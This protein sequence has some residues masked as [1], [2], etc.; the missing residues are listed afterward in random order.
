MKTIY[1]LFTAFLM[2]FNMYS[3]PFAGLVLEELDN[4]GAVTGTTY[5]LYAQMNE[6]LVYSMWANEEYSHLIE[7]TTTF[8]QDGFGSDLQSGISTAFFALAPSLEWDSWVTLGDTYTDA[9]STVGELNFTSFSTSSWSFGGTVN[10]DASIF[11]TPDN[12]NCLP[13]A[14]GLVLLGQFTTD[15]T[16]SGFINLRGKDGNGDVWEETGIPIPQIIPGCTDDSYLEYDP[17]AN[18]DDG[19]CAT[20][21]VEGCIDNTACNYNSLANS[22]DSSCVFTT[23]CETCSGETDGTGTIVDNDADDDGVC[24]AD[25]IVGCFDDEACNFN[26]NATDIDNDSCVFATGCDTCSGETDGTGTIVDNDADDDGVCDADEIAGCQDAT[27]CNY[28][29]NATDD[30]DSCIFVDGICETCSGETDGTGTIV[31]NDADDDG[32]CDADEIAGCQD[33][34]ACNYNENATDDDDSCIF[35]DGICETCSGETDGTGTI[36]DNDADDDG[37]CDADEIVGC[38]DDEACNFNVN[39]TDIDND[40]CVFATGCESCSGDTDGTGTIVDNDAD[41]DGVCDADEI[42][43]CQDATACN[44][45]E[46][47]TDEGDCTYVDGICETC[48]NGLIVDNDTDDDGVCDVDEIAGCQEVTACNYNESATDSDN[49]SCVFALGCDTCTGETDGT[50]TVVDN[51]FDDDGVCDADEIAGCQDTTACNY[52]VLA[53]DDDDSCIFPIL[54]CE[55]CSGNPLDGSGTV[56]LSDDDG[57]GICNNNEI[58]GCQDD[59]ACNYN[60]NA[61]DDDDSCI[62]V[63]GICETCSGETD[64]TGTIVDNDADDDGVCDADEI[65]GCFDDEAC[66]FNVNATD[67]DNDSCV[68]AT[69][70]DTCSGETDGTGTIV[71][72]DAD[73]DGVCDADE[74]AGCQDATACNYNENATDDDDSCIF[75]DGICETCSGETDGTGTIVDNDADD[76][77][78]CDADEIAGCQDAT[79]CN[80]NENATDD[81]DS[82]I[83]VDGI[84]ETCSGE[85]DGTGTI[86]DNDADDDGV[87]D[88]DEIVGCFDDEAC[89]FNVNATDIDNDSCVFAT[90][91]ESCSGDTDGTGTIVDNDADD[92]GVCD[93]DEIAGCQDATACN[94]NE[95]ATD[96]DGSCEFAEE[97]YDCDGNCINDADGDEICDELEVAGCQDA[98]AC[99]YNENATDDDGSCEYAEEYYDCDGNC[100]NDADGDEICDELEVAG[101]TDATACNYNEN[102]T[103]DDGSCEYAEE[104]YDCDGNCIND[105]DG[106]EIC[107]EL[108]VAG[109]TDA[110]ACNYNENATDDDGSCEFAEEYYDCDGNCI[111][112]ADGDEICDELEVAGCTDAT[113]CNYNENAT[114]D[115]GSCEYAEEYYDC[116]GNC[117]NDADGD[118]ICDELEVAGCTDATACNYNEN[119][120]DDDGSCEYAEE[121]YDCD[122]NCI[123]DADGDEICDELEVAGCTDAT[124]CNYNENATDDDGSCE[125]AE[126]YYDCDGNCINDADGDEICDELEVAGCTDATA[127]NYNENATDD[128][129]SCEYAEEYYDCDGNCINDAD[130]DEICDELDNCVD[131]FNPD[132]EDFDG[133]GEGDECDPDDGIGIDEEIS[134]SILVFPNPTNGLVNIQYLNSGNNITL[135]II[136]TIGQIIETTE[137]NSFDSYIN[138]STDLGNYGKG[139]YQIQLHDADKILIERVIVD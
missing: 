51:D 104:Y 14:N 15:G 96:D 92:D 25:E 53:T 95:N 81:D 34:T 41:D 22:D 105:A 88:A 85:T 111:N 17:A 108:E 58:A 97:Y 40:S 16:L 100:I 24:D 56:V 75:V 27:A 139:I 103:D 117:I 129:G 116:D 18:V 138:Y 113:A 68:F 2:V 79:A 82:C 102:A 12:V 133:D 30:D 136:N 122:G 13:D 29:E 137:I 86:V 4:G 48:E 39:A 121:Y 77:G 55:T 94:Y 36:V 78:V 114:D 64:G 49:D 6:G 11:R 127:C 45:N 35:V 50:G 23:G 99:N 74:I 63:D 32:V 131:V 65:V 132:Q 107:D 125:Y 80:Y 1:T 69:G 47:A 26:V 70:C 123:N 135:R 118:E 61:T 72:N 62:F 98:T 134:N 115:D 130:G 89:N 84:C 124:A 110:T 7:T 31:D 120:T 91:C 109:C 128:D 44:Y 67:I 28:N 20:L 106:D 101:C 43:G 90:G 9:P 119:A 57:D 112:D 66:N 59:T 46:N 60:E 87:C 33:A 21:V 54:T 8:Y 38:F 93:A 10:S 19:S 73:D 52:N 42:A 71:D 126:E 5:R 76:D 83:F 3:Q 37:V